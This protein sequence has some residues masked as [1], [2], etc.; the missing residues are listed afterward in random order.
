[1]VDTKVKKTVLT[2]AEKRR[3]QDRKKH[4]K[5]RV[6]HVPRDE[7]PPL[8][9][10]PFQP[11]RKLHS[12]LSMARPHAR[13]KFMLEVWS[14]IGS[15]DGMETK[16]ICA[17]KVEP[18]GHGCT[19][20]CDPL[21]HGDDYGSH[22]KP[23]NGTFDSLKKHSC[24]FSQLFVGGCLFRGFK[25]HLWSKDLACVEYFAGI[26]TVAR[27][28]QCQPQDWVVAKHAQQCFYLCISKLNNG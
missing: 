25:T 20:L 3:N 13:L 10:V 14:T 4:R 7:R 1:M 6:P 8:V 12:K 15:K 18:H 21:A 24:R 23:W 9:H 17:L 22:D 27:G 5:D 19:S 26:K 11:R 2:K 28:F 16:S